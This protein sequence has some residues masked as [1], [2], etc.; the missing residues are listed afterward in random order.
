[1]RESERADSGVVVGEEMRET[2]LGD[3][4][5]ELLLGELLVALL[6][7]THQERWRG[8][9]V[10]HVLILLHDDGTQETVHPHVET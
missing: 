1:M 10:D 9:R 5:A 4:L 8:Q 6:K 3:H 2:E 7:P